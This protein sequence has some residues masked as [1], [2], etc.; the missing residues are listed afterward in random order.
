[1]SQF[2]TAAKNAIRAGF[3]GVEIHGANGHLIDQF[4]QDN[5]NKRVDEYGGSIEK[6]AKFAL[7]VV[8]AVCEAIGEEKTALRLSPW[9][10][11]YGK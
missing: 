1:M 8:D 6:R 4:T 3:D 5:T 7:D 9:N 2:A 11:S 10:D